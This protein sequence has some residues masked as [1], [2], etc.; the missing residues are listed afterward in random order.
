MIERAAG[1]HDVPGEVVGVGSALPERQD[2]EAFRSRHGLQEP[3]ALYVGRVD[4]NKGCGQPQRARRPQRRRERPMTRK[5]RRLTIVLTGMVLL[6]GAV[7]LVLAALDEA[8][9]P[10][11]RGWTPTTLSPIRCHVPICA[12]VTH[13]TSAPA[14]TMSISSL[15]SSISSGWNAR[16]TMRNSAV[17]LACETRRGSHSWADSTVATRRVM[18]RL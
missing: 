11:P 14:T 13:A 16:S 7:G 6:S 18:A 5:R 3:F 10:S 17:S 1:N 8:A 4:Q 15:R 9:G 2:P 12:G